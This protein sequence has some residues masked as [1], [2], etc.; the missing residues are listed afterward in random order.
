[1]KKIQIILLLI[2]IQVCNAQEY[3]KIN[4]STV[5]YERNSMFSTNS[6]V[7]T[8]I[9][10]SKLSKGFYEMIIKKNGIKFYISEKGNVD[11]VFKE[12]DSDGLLKCKTVLKEGMLEKV[13]YLDSVGRTTDSL[14]I[15]NKDIERYDNTLKKWTMKT[16]LVY[17]NYSFYENGTVYMESYGRNKD[18]IK[19]ITYYKNGKIMTDVINFYYEKDYDSLG[20]LTRQVD[21]NWI[22]KEIQTLYY[23][24]AKLKWKIIVFDENKIWNA[25]GKITR[26]KKTN[27]S[28]HKSKSYKIETDYYPSGKILQINSKDGKLKQYTEH[29][30]LIKEIPGGIIKMADDMQEKEVNY[31]NAENKTYKIEE[32]DVKSDFP[33]GINAFYN[34]CD[35]NF[36]KP[37]EVELK[38]KIHLSFVI[39]RWLPYKY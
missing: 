10:K 38:G 24:N 3:K 16:S 21:Y 8:N 26:N 31:E 6:I 4:Y 39:E 27:N 13:I 29:G 35:K 15:V 30:V 19:A 34:F 18:D 17:S 28:A 11:G 33:N 7:I 23:E 5:S 36:V 2:V 22:T 1:M 37:S 25:D 12:Y 14:K 32:V 9:N 20:G